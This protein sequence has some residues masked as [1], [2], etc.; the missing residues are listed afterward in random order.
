MTIYFTASLRGKP[1]L[2][3]YYQRIVN[4]LAKQGHAVI[5]DQILKHTSDDVSH[6]SQ[7][8]RLEYFH[9]VEQWLGECDCVVAEISHRSVSV[10]YEISRA[11]HRKKPILILYRDC[12]PPTLLAYQPDESVVCEKYTDTNLESVLDDFLQYTEGTHD[13]RFTFFIRPDLTAHL[14]EQ[15]RKNHTTKSGYLRSL[16][17]SDIQAPH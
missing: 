12:T 11:Q 1:A 2:E 14:E 7:K 16:I 5:A 10:G 4:H 13:T 6:Q 3:A 9:E 15:A 8:E 17:Q